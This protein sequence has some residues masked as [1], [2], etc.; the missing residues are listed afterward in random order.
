M[1]RIRSVHPGLWTDERFVSVSAAARLLFIGLWN[2]C[3]DDGCFVWSPLKLKM[4]LLPAD[5]VDATALLDELVASGM[6][7]RF[8]V[9]GREIGAVRNFRKFQK[10]ERPTPGMALTD[11]VRAFVA[12]SES[13]GTRSD[14]PFP[15]FDGDSPKGRR[16]ITDG[17]SKSGPDGEGEGKGKEAS[18][19]REE[20]NG[21]D[22]SEVFREQI[23]DAFQE[24][25]SITPNLRHADVWL[26]RGLD[27][28]LCL[29]VIRSRLA[30][31]SRPASL[32]YFDDAIAE[33]QAKGKPPPKRSP[34]P[35]LTPEEHET[36]IRYLM[37]RFVENPGIWPPKR[38]PRPDEPGCQIAPHILHEF[39]FAA[40]AA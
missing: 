21:H 1:A 39:G 22:P 17:S 3:D 12:L 32:R 2:E 23:R 24:V 34:K 33:E 26:A 19:P 28:D 20:A 38:G 7:G 4:R 14:R 29:A 6:V 5:P 40:R 13:K 15:S 31:G 8:T 9:E 18:K 27:P 11:E 10:P 37:Q 16:R 35:D 36:A 30:L 25:G